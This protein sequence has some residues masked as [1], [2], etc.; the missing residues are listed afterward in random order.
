MPWGWSID[1]WGET[2]GRS[3]VPRT[4]VYWPP[5]L[6]QAIWLCFVECL[7][8][9]CLHVRPVYWWLTAYNV[10]NKYY[11]W[12]LKKLSITACKNVLAFYESTQVTH[13]LWLV[14][15]IRFVD[16]WSWTISTHQVKVS[17]Y[18]G[19]RIVLK[20]QR[21]FW[22]LKANLVA[23]YQLLWAT[24]WLSPAFHIAQHQW[25]K[26]FLTRITIYSKR[27]FKLLN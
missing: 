11:S 27:P 6:S 7:P 20:V 24:L 12:T 1:R 4:S 21:Y 19:L 16:R 14:D 17:H 2:E 9:D 25:E 15:V 26:T 5:N 10:K 18:Y 3:G 23:A 13:E 22:I 8:P